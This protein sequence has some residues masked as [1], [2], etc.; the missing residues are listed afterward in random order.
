MNRRHQ[1]RE[2][3]RWQWFSGLE[4]MAANDWPGMLRKSYRLRR[5]AAWRASKRW[6]REHR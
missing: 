4:G 2:V 3:R 6:R 5:N 1:I